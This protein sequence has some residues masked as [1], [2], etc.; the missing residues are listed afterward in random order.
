MAAPPPLPRRRALGANEFLLHTTEARYGGTFRIAG[1]ATLSS[2]TSGP[3][4]LSA[5]RLIAAVAAVADRYEALRTTVEVGADGQAVFLAADSG[6]PRVDVRVGASADPDVLTAEAFA[7]TEAVLAAGPEG[8]WPARAPSVTA[9]AMKGTPSA[10]P[11]LPWQVIAF[12]P[13]RAEAGE[14]ASDGVGTD[15]NTPASA[16]PKVSTASGAVVVWLVPHYLADGRSLDFLCAALID[17]LNSD[18]STAAASA[19][20]AAGVSRLPPAMTTLLPPWGGRLGATVAAGRFLVG[21]TLEGVTRSRV[22]KVVP[23]AGAA[24]GSPGAS[25]SDGG[26]ASASAVAARRTGIAVAVVGAPA[27]AR[28]RSGAKAAGVTL[29]AALVGAFAVALVDTGLLAPPGWWRS[30]VVVAVPMDARRASEDLPN[31]AVGNYVGAVDVAMVVPPRPPPS[32]PPKIGADDGRLD[33]GS[34]KKSGGQSRLWVA[35]GAASTALRVPRIRAAAAIRM[36]VACGMVARPQ[37]RG[38]LDALVADP[39]AAGRLLPD[40]FVSNIGRCTETE[41]ANTRAGST[42]AGVTVT[43]LGLW[44]WEAQMGAPLGLYTATVGG[45]AT[46]VAAWTEPFVTAE[47]GRA[48]LAAVVAAIEAA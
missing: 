32:L 25:P 7:A 1:V 27:V 21:S 6:V 36:G 29:G 48:V 40:P 43:R 46:L 34:D 11:H 28:F 37:W 22:R 31:T 30:S 17:A 41:A 16:A 12:L 19:V 15:G 20:A 45:V 2:P 13:P 33:K 47:A 38:F 24:A 5:P 8:L 18:C 4:C 44:D 39:V 9:A 14:G 35:A 26:A 42:A 10:T 3:G 23:A